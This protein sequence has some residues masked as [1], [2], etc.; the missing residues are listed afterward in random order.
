LQ[1]GYEILK[2]GGS[3]LDAVEAAVCVMEDDPHFNAGKGA[4]F[5]DAG[6]NELDASIMDGKTLNAGAVANVWH[7]RNPISLARL[8]MEKSPHVMMAGQGAEAFAN[9]MGMKLVD[10][11]YFY[12]KERWQA[13]QREK[14]QKRG[15][16]GGKKFMAS[17]QDY[18]GTVGAVALDQAGHLAAATSTGGLTDKH[19]GRIGDSPI[20]GAGTYANDASCAV[21]GTGDGEYY[22][23]TVAAHSVSDL[24]QY[25]GLSVRDASQE[26]LDAIRKLG[27]TGGLI[28]IDHQGNIAQLF[29]TPGMYRGKIGRDGKPVI[30]IFK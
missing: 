8:V 13:L 12:T 19:A 15:G 3:S 2:K 26:V 4:V 21:S 22:I 18:H 5:T 23:R 27:G 29:N 7:V 17:A 30:A 11:K 16:G 20:I 24:M 14:A 6:T 1:A 25:R 28:V 9:E 10:P